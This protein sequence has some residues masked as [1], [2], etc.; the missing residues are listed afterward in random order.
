MNIIVLIKTVKVIY[1]QTGTDLKNNYIGPDDI[2]HTLNP[3]DELALEYALAIRDQ[4]PETRIK[5][6]SLGNALAEKGLRRAIAMG[7]D[8]VTHIQC[9]EIE[10]LDAWAVASILAPAC[11]RRGF[12]LVLSGA[13]TPDDNAGLVGQ[14]TAQMLRVP[15]LS[16]VVQIEAPDAGGQSVIHRRVERGDRQILSCRLPAL[17]SIQKG[18][19]T[20]RYPVLS[21]FLRA[22]SW[23][24][25][26]TSAV[27][28]MEGNASAAQAESLTEVLEFVKP[29]PKKREEPTEKKKKMSAMD[30]LKAVTKK[31]SSTKKESGN[32]IDGDSDQ[33]LVRLDT[34]FKETGILEES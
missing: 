31:G 20:A 14:Y 32:L 4:V 6:I 29:G 30:R 16:G 34:V 24:I 18:T 27:E 13:S 26:K 23:S 1:A 5:A 15:H 33:V 3:S 12:D 25:P 2:L 22:E 17:F 21:G 10:T 28:L 19:V 9:E 7:V 11:R 8:E